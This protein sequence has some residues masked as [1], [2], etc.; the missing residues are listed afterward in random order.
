VELTSRAH[1]RRVAFAALL[2]SASLFALEA[3]AADQAAAAQ[4]P[5]EEVLIT[6]SL[7]RGAPAVGV[8]VTN[9]GE[10]EFQET[11]AVTVS[12]LLRNV[13]SIE[14]DAS[15]GAG[16]SPGNWERLTSV[17][18]RGLSTNAGVRTLMLID[19]MRYPVQGHG[20][21]QL[22]PSIIPSLA[23]DH[24][25]ILVDGAS[26]TYGSDAIAGVLNVIM[27]RGYE[28]A[29]TQL[30]AVHPT[31]GGDTWQA[32]QLWGTTWDGGD[33]TLVYEWY[34]A[35]RL[36]R[37]VLPTFTYDYTPWGLDD[38]TLIRSSIPG[39]VSTGAPAAVA[40]IPTG[41][42]ANQGT[43]WCAN[44]YSV[45][46]GSGWDFDTRAPG[47][48]T[49]WTQLLANK[50]VNNELNSYAYADEGAAQQRNAATVT[51]DQTI[52]DGVELFVDGFYS[53]RRAQFRYSG[54]H[55]RPAN[56]ALNALTVPTTNPYY[57]AGAPAGLRVS[58]LL[59]DEVQGNTSGYSRN[60]R[61]AGGFNLELPYDWNGR[62]Y[63]NT[64][65]EANFAAT[66]GSVNTNNV[67]AALGNT[68]AAQASQAAFTKPANIPYLNLFCDALVYQC[69]SPAT[70]AY[71]TGQEIFDEK[72]NLRQWS[73]VFD[74]KV[75]ALP[76]GD[77][78]AAFGADYVSNHYKFIDTNTINSASTAAVTT[79]PSIGNRNVW[80]VYTEVN[81][82][83]FSETNALPLMRKLDLQVS[84]R[85]DHYNDFGGTSNPRVAV[86]WMPIE[87]LTLRGSWGTS[88]RAPAFAETSAVAG[89]LIM[90][91]NALAGAT[92]GNNVRLCPLN[93]STPVSGSAG[94]A[95]I[96]AGLG[97][98][99]NSFPGGI[100]VGGGS[101]GLAGVTRPAG[102]ALGPEKA[103]SWSVGAQ[104]LP[105][106]APG[107]DVHAT[108]FWT[109]VTD[110]IAG[111]GTDLLNPFD[112]DHILIRGE[113]GFD[114]A[115]AAILS[116]PLSA[117]NPSVAS[118]ISF[119]Q[120]GAARNLGSL[121]L[122]GIDFFAGY[123]W[124]L[125][126]YGIWDASITGTYYLHRETV[127][128]PGQEPEDA[129]HS[130]DNL[131]GETREAR[132]RYRA[133]LG[134]NDGNG[135]NVAMIL[136]Y[137]SHFFHT[138][139]YPPQCFISGPVCYPGAEQFPDYNNHVPANY[140]FD[141]STGYDLMDRPVNPFLKNIRFAFVVNNVFDR[142]PSFVY[143]IATNGGSF[144]H[145]ASASILGRVFN[146][147]I[148]KTW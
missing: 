22:D 6:G 113:P 95:L 133:R 104:L 8:P 70:L 17:D 88:F 128:G 116:N 13:P 89:R 115:V 66:R 77:L 114:A 12:E 80:A 35:K 87:S 59:T 19:T 75:F 109:E 92:G 27:R 108:Y 46:K 84:W 120:E 134:W 94:A 64:S 83:I 52:I 31:V 111:G 119:I 3:K 140:I 9:L 101:D 60:S 28:G 34:D 1:A 14:V 62:V 37:A 137:K 38:R 41:F 136:N 33:L 56:N 21:C 126:N 90:P 7:I 26:A 110:T 11:G 68:V 138:Q 121:K 73:A 67:N 72:W 125:G 139:A 51:F 65:E 93:S 39:I 141:L 82:P 42:A 47:P 61:W 129:Y 131:P 55:N 145:D 16:S 100:S 98:T 24:I 71:I 105:T 86:D 50:G 79:T 85:H 102:F 18:L 15:V 146:V 117:V 91:V 106:F 123:D 118:S 135:L 53:N 143:R 142:R 74:G 29:I 49:T 10:Q 144:A 32:S 76:G 127:G 36:P 58:Y 45:P 54:T 44:C 2:G 4:P 97:F 112:R 30:K 57:P 124:E 25:D 23:L 81:A 5:V 69:N 48:T 130:S 40:G 148:T 103:T 43:M 63:F 96:A 99:C 122:N 147:T 132:F 20:T 107:L 78:R